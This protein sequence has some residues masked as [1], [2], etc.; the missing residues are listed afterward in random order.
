MTAASLWL[1]QTL[2][3]ASFGELLLGGGAL[4]AHCPTER[5]KQ[6]QKAGQCTA[7]VAK[8]YPSEGLHHW[9]IQW[10][11]IGIGLGLIVREIDFS[12]SHEQPATVN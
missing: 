4:A 12:Y 10:T 8:F 9:H 11:K 7:V 2:L 5:A 3:L 1:A 6:K